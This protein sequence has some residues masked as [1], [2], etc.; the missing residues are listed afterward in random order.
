MGCS[1][2]GAGFFFYWTRRIRSDG[3]ESGCYDEYG[4]GLWWLRW[5]FPR[6]MHEK[7]RGVVLDGE[8]E[9]HGWWWQCVLFIWVWWVVAVA[10]V[11]LWWQLLGGGQWVCWDASGGGNVLLWL[12]IA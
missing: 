6:S 12:F 11:G 5:W 7:L 9:V 3:K 10:D 1:G 8:R 4:G 2:L